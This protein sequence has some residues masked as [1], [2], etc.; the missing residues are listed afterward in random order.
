MA[1]SKYNWDEITDHIKELTLFNINS[2]KRPPTM[3]QLYRKLKSEFKPTAPDF[4]IFLRHYHKFFGLEKSQ[5]NYESYLYDL[6]GKYNE[7]SL[8]QLAD[9]LK[10]TSHT[11]DAVW[12]FIRFKKKDSELNTQ[13]YLHTMSQKLKEELGENILFIT[14]DHDTLTVLC[15]DSATKHDI[16]YYFK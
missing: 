6:V 15:K 11:S 13:K 1:N 3:Q 4:K 14:F 5:K 8:R 7:E 10:I 9:N 12:L 16:E 2:N